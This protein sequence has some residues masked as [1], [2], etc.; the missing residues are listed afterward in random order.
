VER[1]LDSFA[2]AWQRAY[3]ETREANPVRA[4]SSEL[5]DLRMDCLNH[6]FDEVAALTL[7]FEHAD[8]DLVEHAV[9]ALQ[10]VGYIKTC[11]D[12]R[13]LRERRGPPTEPAKRAAYDAL[14][15]ELM[16]VKALAKALRYAEGSAKIG[17]LVQEAER[18][19]HPLLLSDALFWQGIFQRF[20]GAGHEAERSLKRAAIAAERGAD[21]GRAASAWDQL[22]FLTATDTLNLDDAA[23]WLEHGA[24]AG[25]RAGEDPARAALHERAAAEIA[26]HR[27]RLGEQTTALKKSIELYHRAGDIVQE[28]EAAATSGYLLALVGHLD[29]GERDC[30]LGLRLIEDTLGREHPIMAQAL[31][32]VGMVAYSR[33][34][35]AEATRLA[36]RAIAIQEAAYGPDATWTIGTHVLLIGALINSGHF[37]EA[38][39]EIARAEGAQS[40][41]RI[42]PIMSSVTQMFKG[43]LFF[44]QGRLREALPLLESSYQSIVRS[45]GDYSG[46]A[47]ASFTL[48][49]TLWNTGRDRARAVRLA[50]EARAAAENLGPAPNYLALRSAIDGW[51]RLNA[52]KSP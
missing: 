11:L 12:V 3:V 27:H 45:G 47:I 51:L 38:E 30:A 34:Q 7:L 23:R 31:A 26:V 17:A 44:N 43:R 48:A 14:A 22:A 40:R 21:D 35:Y 1:G 15:H 49:Q 39:S 9:Q 25:E 37:A 5:M 33:F 46:I 8:A 42:H 19:D 4:E 20:T 16:G 41:V 52:P 2:A 13:A 18:L 28:A 24:A 32:C 10:G 36:R 50:R 6:R 29:E